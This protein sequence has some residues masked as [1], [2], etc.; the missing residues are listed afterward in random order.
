LQVHQPQCQGCSRGGDPQVDEV[1]LQD[2]L[3]RGAVPWDPQV[4]DRSASL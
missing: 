3:Q 4:R 2:H 1:A